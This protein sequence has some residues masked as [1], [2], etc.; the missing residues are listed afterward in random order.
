MGCLTTFK[1][2]ATWRETTSISQNIRN[3]IAAVL[4]QRELEIKQ[5]DFQLYE[6][7]AENL[8]A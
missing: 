5:E 6:Q 1:C 3:F 7:F 4:H 8:G 2:G